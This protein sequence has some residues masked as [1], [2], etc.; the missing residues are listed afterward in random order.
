MVV[1]PSL[2]TPT[3]LRGERLYPSSKYGVAQKMGAGMTR[4]HYRRDVNEKIKLF[5]AQH[6]GD[7][8][9]ISLTN[10]LQSAE[11]FGGLRLHEHGDCERLRPHLDG[12]RVGLVGHD[13]I[14]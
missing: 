8:P 1:P 9:L 7:V 2:K 4:P 12:V 10:C 5:A 14:G 3:R 13:Q 6:F 11:Q